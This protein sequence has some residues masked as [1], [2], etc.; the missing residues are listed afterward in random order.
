MLFRSPGGSR[1]IFTLRASI[2]Y[3]M[4]SHMPPCTPTTSATTR[5]P[6]SG[7]KTMLPRK[8]RR[9]SR[10]R[11]DRLLSSSRCVSQSDRIT[12][13]NSHSR[14]VPDISG[15]AGTRALFVSACKK[16]GLIRCVD[17]IQIKQQ[18]IGFTR[19]SKTESRV[20]AL[21]DNE[22]QRES[23]EIGRAHV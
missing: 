7:S 18:N 11:A 16:E 4:S 2:V 12:V 22:R 21:L 23:F 10:C 14:L 15:R 5:R 13:C 3:A 8:R 17:G 9:L 6:S 19:C 20:H 1:T